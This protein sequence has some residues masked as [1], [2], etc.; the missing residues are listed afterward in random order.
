MA[1]PADD[2]RWSAAKTERGSSFGAVAAAY[3]AWRPGYPDDVVAFLAGAPEGSVGPRRLLD[4]GAGTG[5]LTERLVAAGHDVL[6]ADT[7]ADMLAELTAR[8]PD[9]PTFVAGA[10]QLPLPDDDVDGIVAAQ[11]AHWFDPVPAARE[12]ARVLRPGGVVGFVW[13]T[14]DDSEPWAAALGALLAADSRDQGGDRPEGNQSIVDAF[15]AELD[16]TVTRY[17]TRWTHR[18]PPEAVVGR[19]ASS[20]R[21]AVLDGAGREAYLNRVRDLLATHPDTRG[22]HELDVPYVTTAWRLVPR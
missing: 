12:F 10:E 2:T 14:R 3:A 17:S 16:A 7:S 4:L 20:S 11:A 19:W 15:A 13:N 18:V 1:T 22:R 5:L 6:A 21:V 8:L 9:V